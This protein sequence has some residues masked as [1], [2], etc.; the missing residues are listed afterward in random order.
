MVHGVLNLICVAHNNKPLWLMSKFC[1][2]LL[3][4]ANLPLNESSGFHGGEYEDVLSSG[5]LHWVV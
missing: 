4:V 2:Y 5:L 3:I 1:V